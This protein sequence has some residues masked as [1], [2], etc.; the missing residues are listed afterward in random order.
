MRPA[1]QGICNALKR[2]Y[3]VETMVNILSIAM[4]HSRC[5]SSTHMVTFLPT[6][7]PLESSCLLLCI[8]HDFPVELSCFPFLQ[9]ARPLGSFFPLN[10]TVSPEDSVAAEE[11]ISLFRLKC[12]V[13]HSWIPWGPM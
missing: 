11:E 10:V 1:I 5:P 8:S 12:W 3:K 7:L 9:P 2:Y 6:V 13:D 4:A